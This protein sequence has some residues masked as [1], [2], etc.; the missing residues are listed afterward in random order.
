MAEMDLDDYTRP[1]FTA[2][3]TTFADLAGGR[4]Q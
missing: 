3:R 2:V 1:V 4:R